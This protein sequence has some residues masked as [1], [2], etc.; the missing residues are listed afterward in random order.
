MKK[1]QHYR[2]GNFY[3]IEEECKIQENGV[4]MEGIIY[5]EYG[6]KTRYVR[7]KVEFFNKFKLVGE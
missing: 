6:F 2:N 7:S 5:R 3:V 4:W 1:Y